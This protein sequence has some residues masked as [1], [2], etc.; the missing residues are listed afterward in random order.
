MLTLRTVPAG[1]SLAVFH[2]RGS[3]WSVENP[4]GKVICL[5]LDLIV[6]LCHLVR[7]RHGVCIVELAVE[8]RLAVEEVLRCGDDAGKARVVHLQEVDV[9]R[10]DICLDA[11]NGCRPSLWLVRGVSR[12]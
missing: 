11:G 6:V 1:T 7:G 8:D 5:R 3:R 12:Q 10:G 9:G 2:M 4:V